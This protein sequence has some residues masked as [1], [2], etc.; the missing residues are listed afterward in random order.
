MKI[1]FD[2]RKNYILDCI[3][4]KGKVYVNELSKELKISS[5]TIRRDLNKLEKEGL[6]NRIHGGAINLD[7]N[8]FETPFNTRLNKNLEKKQRIAFAAVNFISK[9]DIIALDTG[10]TTLQIAKLLINARNLTIITT[11]MHIVGQLINNSHIKLILPA[12]LVRPGEGSLTGNFTINTLQNFYFD[13]LFLSASSIDCGKGITDYTSEDAAIKKQLIKNSREI[14]AV[15]DSSK[16]N[17]ISLIQIADLEQ[18][19]AWA[20][21]Y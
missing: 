18:K 4:K 16:F 2:K 12:G 11:N 17:T 19:H 3:K 9:G 13:K 5:M 8:V 15:M 1:S 7:I 6:I 10:T 14:I 20:N 21:I